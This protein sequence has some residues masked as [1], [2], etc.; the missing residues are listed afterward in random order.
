MEGLG[1]ARASMRREGLA[2]RGVGGV[3]RALGLGSIHHTTEVM[4]MYKQ[5]YRTGHQ[6]LNFLPTYQNLPAW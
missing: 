5:S 6:P 1:G 2:W 4:Y 3:C